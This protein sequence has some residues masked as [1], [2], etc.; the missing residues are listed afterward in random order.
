MRR[1]LQALRLAVLWLAALLILF[2]EWG[3]EPLSRWLG[4]LAHLPVLAWL[5][6][7]IA[8]LPPYAALALFGLPA[9]ALLP[10]KLL[11]LYWLSR[12]HVVLGLGVI[13]AAKIMG[14]ALVARLFFLTHHS[15]MRLAWFAR[16]YAAWSAWK[17]RLIAMV[18]GS[19]AWRLLRQRQQRVKRW[20]RSAW[21]VK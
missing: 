6:R 10:V 20:L 17:E 19:A 2:E 4:R 14:T 13:V 5:E 21:R 15:L 1:L 3:W 7:R 12:G 16:Y 8:Q 18:R 11:A 9:L